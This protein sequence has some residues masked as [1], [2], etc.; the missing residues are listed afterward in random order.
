[1]STDTPPTPADMRAA[2]TLHREA[3]ARALRS[4]EHLEHLASLAEGQSLQFWFE[5]DDQGRPWFFMGTSDDYYKILMTPDTARRILGVVAPGAA[6]AKDDA[7]SAARRE[8][9]E[10]CAR[11]V[12]PGGNARGFLETHGDRRELAALIRA[13]GDR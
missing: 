2:A 3:A 1:M 9:R 11:L 13:R 8:E 6:D 7:I 12:E 5:D 10:A 4:A